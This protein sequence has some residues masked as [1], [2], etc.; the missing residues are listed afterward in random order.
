MSK[1]KTTELLAKEK[2]DRV[3]KFVAHRKEI[4]LTEYKAASTEAEKFIWSEML[5]LLY[6]ISIITES[7]NV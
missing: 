7:D 6:D 5:E 4:Y 3:S 2:L 1:N